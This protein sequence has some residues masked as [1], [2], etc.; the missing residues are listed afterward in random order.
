M[1]R[2]LITF[3]FDCFLL[4]WGPPQALVLKLMHPLFVSSQEGNRGQSRTERA[5]GDVDKWTFI[6]QHWHSQPQD[7]SGLSDDQGHPH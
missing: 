6:A 3:N 5:V 2:R 4:Y 7:L 1:A